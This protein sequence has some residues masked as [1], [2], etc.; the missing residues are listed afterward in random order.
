MIGVVLRITP[1]ALA[2]LLIAV[3]VHVVSVLTMPALAMR[4]SSHIL[5]SRAGGEGLR[6]LPMV[7]PGAEQ[8]PFA[9]PAMVTA[10]CAFDITEAPF[11]IRAA[12]TDAFT[13]VTV[14]SDKGAVIHGLTDK[15]A[16]RRQLDV[17]LATEQ[18]LRVLESQDPKTGRRPKSACACR[19]CA[20]SSLSRASRPALPTSQR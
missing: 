8:T 14:L 11:R 16:T 18:Q 15:A 2:A 12:M 19:H 9:D 20:V 7:R 10:L 3:I 6:L 4:T 1:F 5:A 17:V 13:A